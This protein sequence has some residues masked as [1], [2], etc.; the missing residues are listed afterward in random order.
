MVQ[1]KGCTNGTRCTV[2]REVT[3]RVSRRDG[4]EDILRNTWMKQRKTQQNKQ[5]ESKKGET[6]AAKF[7]TRMNAC[8]NFP[9]PR[10]VSSKCL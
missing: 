8:Q 7:Q 3:I 4:V 2:H 6:R 5:N 10:V 9:D 1:R